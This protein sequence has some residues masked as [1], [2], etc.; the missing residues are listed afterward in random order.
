MLF[1]SGITLSTQ[2]A[3][4]WVIDSKRLVT[5]PVLGSISNGGFMHDVYEV[6]WLRDRAR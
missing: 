4:A 1:R 5:D 2:T 3:N 6:S